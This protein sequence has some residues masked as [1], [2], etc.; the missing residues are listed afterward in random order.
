MG[1]VAH[2]H[3][4]V[5]LRVPRRQGPRSGRR[6]VETGALRRCDGSGVDPLGGVR[7]GAVGRLAGALAPHRRG[8]RGAGRV[9]RADEQ[10]PAATGPGEGTRAR[11][12][13][14]AQADVAPAPVARGDA[15]LDEPDPLQDVEVVGQQ[16]PGQTEP[17][18]E[19]RGRPVGCAQVLDDRQP[20]RLAQGGVHRG[21]LFDRPVHRHDSIDQ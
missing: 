8:A 7:A 1:T 5:G 4:Q 15:P 9:V 18:A 3:H 12:R 11:Q 6:Q 17:G 10:G 13:V 2:G 20:H 21:A 16:V 19:V 14:V